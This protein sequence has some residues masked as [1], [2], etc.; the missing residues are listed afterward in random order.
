MPAE[1]INRNPPWSRE[2]TLLALNLYFRLGKLP[3]DSHPEVIRLSQILSQLP[4]NRVPSG[5]EKFRNPNGVAMKLANL[6]TLDPSYKGR[7]WIGVSS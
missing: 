1:G 7:A 5:N 3:D 4:T 2:E 6:A